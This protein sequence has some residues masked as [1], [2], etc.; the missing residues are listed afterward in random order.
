MDVDTESHGAGR[1]MFGRIVWLAALVRARRRVVVV[2]L[3]AVATSICLSVPENQDLLAA[4]KSAASMQTLAKS[5]VHAANMGATV[6]NMPLTAC[7]NTGNPPDRRA[8]SGALYYAAVEKNVVIFVAGNED[9]D[10]C[11]TNPE[12]GS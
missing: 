2:G 10:S 9:S 12:Y 4:D 8:L 11:K 5:I 7:V 1:G 6:V 3:L